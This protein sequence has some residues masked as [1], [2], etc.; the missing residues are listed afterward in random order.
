MFCF[1]CV[2][3]QM[4]GFEILGRFSYLLLWSKNINPA[5]VLSKETN[6]KDIVLYHYK[7]SSP[8]T[9]LVWPGEIFKSIA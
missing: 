1:I 5:T 9:T 3:K 4:S 6:K 2:M 8:R 7:M